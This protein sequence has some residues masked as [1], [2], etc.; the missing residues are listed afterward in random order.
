MTIRT[1][2]LPLANVTLLAAKKHVAFLLYLATAHFLIVTFQSYET[3][4]CLII[5]SRH[6]YKLS[7]INSM[8]NS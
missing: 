5:N 7:L 4:S 6:V 2:L 1:L 8:E 3:R